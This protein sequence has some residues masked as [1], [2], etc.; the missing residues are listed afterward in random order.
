MEDST[1]KKKLLPRKK[2]KSLDSLLYNSNNANDKSNSPRLTIERTQIHNPWLLLELT[3]ITG[4]LTISI[5]KHHLNNTNGCKVQFSPFPLLNNIIIYLL[6]SVKMCLPLPTEKSSSKRITN[7]RARMGHLK[8]LSTG[9][10]HLIIDKR[11]D[12]YTRYQT[13]GFIMMGVKFIYAKFYACIIKWMIR[14][15]NCS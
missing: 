2:K 12:A 7:K 9:S 4:R 11:L 10:G 8:D 6:L 13:F 14:P 5:R 3:L 15:K 1:L